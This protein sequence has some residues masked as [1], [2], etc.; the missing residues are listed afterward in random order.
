VQTGGRHCSAEREEHRGLL[1]ERARNQ[2]ESRTFLPADVGAKRVL[3]RSTAD[4]FPVMGLGL[5]RRARCSLYGG[6]PGS[7]LPWGRGGIPRGL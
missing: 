7:W 2:L 4:S 5:T 6:A 1:V 3:E